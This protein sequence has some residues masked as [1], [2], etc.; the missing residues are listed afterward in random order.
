MAALGGIPCTFIHGSIPEPKDTLAL[1]KPLGIDGYG[2]QR[3][4][5]GDSE[6]SVQCV[7]YTT[8]EAAEVWAQ[9]V[10]ALQGQLV[11]IVNDWGHTHARCLLCRMSEPRYT[12]ALFAGGARCEII[13]EGVVT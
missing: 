5:K 1:W 8:P 4:G 12:P 7:V 2:A 10:Q 6:F 9:A 11:T 3:T 13:V